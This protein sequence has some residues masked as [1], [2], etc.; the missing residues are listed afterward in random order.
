MIKNI[1]RQKNTDMIKNYKN[2]YSNYQKRGLRAA[3]DGTE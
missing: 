3:K 2:R 1:I